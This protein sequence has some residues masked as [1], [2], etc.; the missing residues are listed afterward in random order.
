MLKVLIDIPLTIIRNNFQRL[1]V[2]RRRGI[3]LIGTLFF[4]SIFAYYPIALGLLVITGVLILTTKTL[5]IRLHILWPSVWPAFRKNAIYLSQRA[6]SL[7]IASPALEFLY[8]GSL[9]LISIV[10][11]LSLLFRNQNVISVGNV[12]LFLVCLPGMLD[13]SY[14]VFRFT[15]LTWARTI[16]KI[17][18]AFIGS[19]FLYIGSSISKQIAHSITLTDPRYFPDFVGWLTAMAM[20][21]LYIASGILLL[22]IWIIFLYFLSGIAAVI[23]TLIDVFQPKRLVSHSRSTASYSLEIDWLII[24]TRLISMGAS[25]FFILSTY[26]GLFYNN[27]KYI[28]SSLEKMLVMMEY[29]AQG[30]CNSLR[31]GEVFSYLQDEKISVAMRNQDSYTFTSRNCMIEQTAE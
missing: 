10:I 11:L 22:A 16:G 1:S 29:R 27:E 19:V 23:H 31:T 18:L 2:N 26:F 5:L 8:I 30:E 17:S 14:Q 3:F 4:L 15:R 28:T 24:T 7:L 25:I 6:K 12:I 21:A 13:L 20:P 9:L